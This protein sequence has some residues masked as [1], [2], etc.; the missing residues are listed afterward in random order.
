MALI[1]P[2]DLTFNGEEI[3]SVSE[4]VFES[5]FEKPELSKFH[6]I[7]TGIVAKKQIVI[8]GRL[9]G[10]VGAQS[11]GCDPTSA[12]NTLGMSEKFW[13]PAVVS[14][15]LTECWTNL[16]ETFFVW[17]LKQGIKKYDLDGTDFLNYVTEMLNDAILEAIFRIAWFG[18]VDAAD[19]NASPAGILTAGTNPLYFNK[20]DG[21]WKQAYA[22]VAANAARL[23]AGI[24]SRN[25]QATKTLQEF[26]TA[27]TTNNVV[28]TTLQ[29][30]KFGAD[31][32]L[33]AKDDIV[34]VCTQSVA[35]QYERELTARNAAYTTERLENG[36]QVLKSSG[37]ELYSFEL[38][39]RIIRAYYDNGTVYYKPHRIAMY[40]KANVQVGTE[41]ETALGELDII[42]DKVTKKNHIDFMFNIDAKIIESYL[43]QFA[44]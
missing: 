4:A 5:G 39:D 8:L 12:T 22:I 28:T 43:V 42:F 30:M 17:G 3:K 37:Y 23:T 9:S 20:I 21:L 11:G 2:A 36:I 7:V 33:R 27:D 15:R 26:Q 18:D 34:F 25:G 24:T 32:R 16:K 40:S 38:W 13:E 1:T 10:L 6:T 44:Y 41:S 29:N 31:T 14:D 35:D 19:V